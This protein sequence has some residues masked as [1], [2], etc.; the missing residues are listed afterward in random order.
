MVL[1]WRLKNILRSAND[2]VPRGLEPRT[3]RLLAVR[4]NQLSYETC[5]IGGQVLVLECSAIVG[6]PASEPNRNS[7]TGI[8]TRVAREAEY[9]NQLD[10]SGSGR[11]ISPAVE[12]I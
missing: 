1:R 8:R 9:P 5:D 11:N 10:Y 3:L 7:A 4:S 12:K 6:S 2:M